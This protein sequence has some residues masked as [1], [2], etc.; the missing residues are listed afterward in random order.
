VICCCFVFSSAVNVDSFFA[1]FTAL[2]ALPDDDDDEL[3]ADSKEGGATSFF[4]STTH[5]TEEETGQSQAGVQRNGER[6]AAL[7][8]VCAPRCCTLCLQGLEASL[9]ALVLGRAVDE[10]P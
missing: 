6:E 8:R 3:D 9:D 1:S 2:D 5:R 10:I 4:L 7:Q